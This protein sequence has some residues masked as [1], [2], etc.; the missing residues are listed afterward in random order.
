[1]NVPIARVENICNRKTVAFRDPRNFRQ[2]FGEPGARDHGVHCDHV[3]ADAAHGAEGSFAS[4]P[5]PR[6]LVVILRHTNIVSTI[7]AADF[8]DGC[9]S[10]PETFFDAVDLDE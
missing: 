8:D 10:F 5:E 9:G 6:T 1:M 2:H 4:E 3:G 7:S